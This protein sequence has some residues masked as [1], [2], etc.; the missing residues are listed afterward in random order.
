M[1]DN[2]FGNTDPGRV[3]TNNEDAF[4]ARTVYEGRLVLAAVIDGVGGYEGG[5]VAA[6]LAKE[7]IEK[8]FDQPSTDFSQTLRHALVKANDA[9][10]QEAAQNDKVSRMACVATVALADPRNNRFHY[11]HIGDTRLYLLREDSLVK[12]THDHSFVGYLED[13]KRLSEKEAMAHPKRNEI[14]KALGFEPGIGHQENAIETGTSAFLPG[15]LLMLCSD[16]LTDLVNSKTIV[17]LLTSGGTLQQKVN[18][19]VATANDAGGKD[20]ITVVLVQHPKKAQQ[21]AAV[22]ER[23][24]AAAETKGEQ[25]VDEVEPKPQTRRKP[26]SSMLPLV[27]VL[28][29]A[30]AL[31][32]VWVLRNRGQKKT[33]QPIG[34]IQTEE[35]VQLSRAIAGA[36][37]YLPLAAFAE[38][39]TV[40]TD[41]LHITRDSLH[42]NGQGMIIKAD[43]AFNGPAIYAPG[44]RFLL[45][46]NMVFENFRVAVQ[47][48]AGAIQFRNVRFINCAAPL[49]ASYRFSDG[50]LNGRL[51]DSLYRID[52]RPAADSLSKPLIP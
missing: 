19:L 52:S 47:A 3:R 20:N 41:T 34:V 48:P 38:M 21:M 22:A 45:L 24:N 49:L 39:T 44:A 8:S 10:Y 30:L 31:A 27:V 26:R 29:L 28:L 16:G 37:L 23:E 14:N 2:F 9:I 40:L 35:E 7:I 46:E 1:A 13:N 6:A 25:E 36:G 12:I 11:A 43:S 5:E 15:D 42:L 4:V 18:K 50:V 32:T 33:S 51:T 17:S